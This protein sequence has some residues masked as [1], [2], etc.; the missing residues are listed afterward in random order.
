MLGDLITNSAERGGFRIVGQRVTFGW[1]VF[2]L[3]LALG[4]ANFGMATVKQTA[5]R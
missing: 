1:F 2:M 4:V 3:T 5:K